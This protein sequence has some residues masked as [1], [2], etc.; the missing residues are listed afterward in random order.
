MIFIS[1]KLQT[2]TTENNEETS[3]E[4]ATTC[5]TLKADGPLSK[6]KTSGICA[7]VYNCGIING[8]R[9]LYGCE[10][11]TQVYL[12]LIWLVKVLI[13]FPHLLAYDDACHLKKFITNPVRANKSEYSKFLVTLRLVVDKMHFANHV[14]KWCRRNV[15]PYTDELFQ[16]I[17]TE[18]CEQTFHFISNFK[19]ATKHMS[20]GTYNIFMLRMC[21]MFNEDRLVRNRKR[22][23]IE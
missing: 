22:M 11:L 12:F 16:N 20:Y 15:N 8:V 6:C 7:S 21:T 3:N 17:N 9:E 1:F 14:D 2:T 19:Y 5:R 10:S 13:T 18:A 4:Q 23:K